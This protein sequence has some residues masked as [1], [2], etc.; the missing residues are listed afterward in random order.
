MVS[1]INNPIIS[2][3]IPTN[4]RINTLKKTLG[5]FYLDN[6]DVDENLYE[7]CIADNSPADDAVEM[8]K[9]FFVKKNLKYKKNNASGFLNSIEALKMGSADF[10]KLHNNYSTLKKGALRTIIKMITLKKD[11]KPVI[12]FSNGSI[13]NIKTSI[14]IANFDRFLNKIS[15]WSTWSTAFGIWHDDFDI[16]CKNININN[17][18]PHT[19]LLFESY[20]KN[21]FVIDNN[22]YFKNLSVYAKGGYHLTKTFCINYI[23]MIKT[24]LSLNIIRRQTYKKIRLDIL[25]FFF[26]PWYANVFLHKQEYTFD[27]SNTYELLKV[28][29]NKLEIALFYIIFIINCLKIELK[30]FVLKITAGCQ[31]N[32]SNSFQK[33]LD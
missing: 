28:N 11:E 29:Y 14:E 33:K 5:S 1:D 32:Y 22:K 24:I 2:F 16:L 18:F 6:E 9:P 31:F 3:C 10:L 4:G 12:F 20:S 21:N 25:Y 13:T 15:Y 19:S 8:L 23:D 26:P 7:I 30:R 17:M 27:V